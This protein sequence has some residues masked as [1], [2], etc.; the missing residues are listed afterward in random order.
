MRKKYSEIT[1]F[2]RLK[3]IDV[4]C[5][6]LHYAGVRGRIMAGLAAKGNLKN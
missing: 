5:N 6:R 3:M 2:N 1:S 4:S